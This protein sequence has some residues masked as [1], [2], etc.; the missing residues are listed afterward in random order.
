MIH[1]KFDKE[2]VTSF[3]RRKNIFKSHYYKLKRKYKNIKFT[4]DYPEDLI[5]IKMLLKI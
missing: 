3:I 4:V 1:S 2:H 5:V